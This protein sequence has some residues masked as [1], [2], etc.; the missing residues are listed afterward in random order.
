MIYYNLKLYIFKVVDKLKSQ[1]SR[2]AL[3]DAAWLREPR[4]VQ[5]L[6]STGT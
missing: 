5:E 1:R 4:F 3:E 6:W 2:G